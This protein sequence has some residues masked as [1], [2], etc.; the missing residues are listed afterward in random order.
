MEHEA[1]EKLSAFWKEHGENLKSLHST[2]HQS[3]KFGNEAAVLH[4]I[5]AICESSTSLRMPEFGRFIQNLTETE[6]P[7]PLLNK[8]YSHNGE[9][10]EKIALNYREKEQPIPDFIESKITDAQTIEA[11]SQWLSENRALL[12]DFVEQGLHMEQAIDSQKEQWQNRIEVPN[13]SQR[14]S[15]HN[16]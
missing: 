9:Q 14:S 16:L 3:E 6:D 12:Q 13:T 5:T 11:L 4:G 2:M 8:H 1:Y 7:L 15:L 10:A